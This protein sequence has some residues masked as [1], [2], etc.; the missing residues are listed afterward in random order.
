[1]SSPAF[2]WINKSTR[3]AAFDSRLELLTLAYLGF[4]VVLWIWGWLHW[5]W[6]L[7]LSACLASAFAGASRATNSPRETDPMRGDAAPAFPLWTLV[8]VAAI[9]CLWSLYSGAGGFTL[10][11]PDWDKHSAVLKDLVEAHWPVTYEVGENEIP[12]VYYLA[13]YLPAALVGKVAGWWWANF[14]L[15][16]W[17][18][19]G[20]CLAM[21]WFIRLVR[22]RPLLSAIIFVFANGLDFLG[23]RLVS[24][25]PLLEGT[26]HIDW[27][28]GWLFLNFPGHM[29]QLTWAPQHSIAAWLVIGLLV[30]RLPVH[31]GLSRIGLPVALA[32]FWSPFTV[33]GLAPF[34]LL[35]LVDRRGRAALHWMNLAAAPILLA[36]ILYYNSTTSTP[37]RAWL[38]DAVDIRT[39]GG[40][41]MLFHLFEWGIFYFFARELRASDDRWTRL[42]CWFLPVVLLSV[43]FYR[44]GIFNDFCMRVP[45]PA[46]FLLWA[47]VARSI[48]LHARQLEGRILA[49]LLVVG[50]MGSLP[51][52]L[53]A[54]H[55]PSLNIVEEADRVH[56]PNLAA[57][58]FEQY[59]GSTDSLFFRSLARDSTPIPIKPNPAAP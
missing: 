15:L 53:R 23:Q 6:A 46:L 14:T 36:A 56:V 9:A 40:R 13:Y 18:A 31:D 52:L 54:W 57:G 49:L 19:L 37:P 11:N 2:R 34:C 8:I 3:I 39:D 41:F 48:T 51:E 58:I 22:K 28:A 42:V 16:V 35:A 17:T 33:M 4:P 38:W 47:G 24:G 27:W 59:L 50:A 32:A 12:L 5:M 20:V 44:L 7:A 43:S 55:P 21:F 30:V 26:E 29:S 25:E 1:M 10:Q 45:I